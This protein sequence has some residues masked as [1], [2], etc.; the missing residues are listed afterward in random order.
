MIWKRNKLKG[1]YGSIP[2]KP[3]YEAYLLQFYVFTEIIL[4]V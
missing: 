2:C 4:A 3:L 1:T